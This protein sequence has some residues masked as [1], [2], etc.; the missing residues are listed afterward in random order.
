[1][2]DKKN[3]DYTLYLCTD[4][5][6]MST[7]TVEQAVEQAILGGC[8]IVQLREKKCKAREFIRIAEGVKAVT[9]K[10]GIPLIINDRVDIALAVDADGVHVG[11][12]D[13]PCAMVRQLLGQDKIIGVSAHNR[14][15]AMAAAADGADYLGVGAIY[16]TNTKE[17]AGV[18]T[19]QTFASLR[20]AV[21][22][23]I[24]AIGGV[25]RDRVDY[26]KGLG[27]DGMAVVSAVIS[28]RDIQGAAK[29]LVNLWRR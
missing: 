24:V 1:M 7:M 12:S 10:Y 27:A 28:A 14:E 13:M 25:N 15:E 22:L 21:G 3:I 9:Q 26:V 4:R 16:S 2:I 11:Q 6:L 23:P 17:D 29:E 19:P 18:I 5:E 8:G 20:A